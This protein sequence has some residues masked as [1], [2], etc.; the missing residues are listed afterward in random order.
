MSIVRM[1]RCLV[2]TRGLSYGAGC[3]AYTGTAPLGAPK[4]PA[5]VLWAR[6]DA[7]EILY[8]NDLVFNVL[9]LKSG[10]IAIKISN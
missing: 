9:A 7:A 10:A 5:H 8:I 3:T 2:R 6:A 1:W 4:E